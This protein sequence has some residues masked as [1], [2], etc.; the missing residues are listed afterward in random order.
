MCVFKKK[1]ASKYVAHQY[2]E[3]QEATSTV[4][5]SG[6]SVGGG[7]GEEKEEEEEGREGQ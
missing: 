2:T 5:G 4:C 6:D 1:R 7:R 3:H